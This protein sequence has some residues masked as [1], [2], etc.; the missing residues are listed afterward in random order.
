MGDTTGSHLEKLGIIKGLESTL[1]SCKL[2]M[3][4]ISAQKDNFMC[5]L[6]MFCNQ[7]DKSDYFLLVPM[8]CIYN[9]VIHHKLSSWSNQYHI[10][11]FS[12][13]L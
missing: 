5:I 6:N 10:M 9:P 4:N 11:R 3:V 2:T 7:I 13:S 1:R 8:F 12:K